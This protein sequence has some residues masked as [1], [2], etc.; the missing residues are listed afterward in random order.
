MIVVVDG[1]DPSYLSHGITTSKLPNMAKFVREGWS[2]TAH[3]AMPSF[4]N[5]NNVSI[6]TGAPTAKHGI[7]GNFFLDK[8]T[9][10]EAMVLDDTLLR[11]T[12]IL[13]QLSK[14]P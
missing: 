1:F 5:P 13:E 4:T 6:I 11:G 7:C 14:L 10:K 9:G 8:E 3:C 12:T 2:T